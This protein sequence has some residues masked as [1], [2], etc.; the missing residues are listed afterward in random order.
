MADGSDRMKAHNIS[1]SDFQKITVAQAKAAHAAGIKYV[2]GSKFE[3]D[4]D[5][6]DAMRH[7]EDLWRES[8]HSRRG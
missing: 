4:Y 6:I 3:P 7:N 8:N 2:V 5:R 1:W